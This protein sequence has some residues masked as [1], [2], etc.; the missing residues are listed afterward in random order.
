MKIELLKFM[1]TLDMKDLPE[2]YKSKETFR[3]EHKILCLKRELLKGNMT[4]GEIKDYYDVDDYVIDTIANK[5]Y[6]MSFTAGEY[7]TEKFRMLR[8]I[9]REEDVNAI[10]EKIINC[11]N[12]KNVKLS[13]E[14]RIM[15]AYN[16]YKYNL[17]DT[18][19]ETVINNLYTRLPE[20]SAEFEIVA[21]A[22]KEF[23]VKTKKFNRCGAHDADIDFSWLDL[24]NIDY[25]FGVRNGKQN[26]RY[27]FK[28]NGREKELSIDRAI[29]VMKILSDNNIPLVDCIVKT[30]LRRDLFNELDEFINSL[31]GDKR[32]R[33]RKR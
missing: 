3:L 24:F 16:M 12:S 8:D 15:F 30:A 22:N 31:V 33:V 20:D 5:M 1:N 13:I 25:Y 4:K 23:G 32:V 6:A 29:E 14:Q 10:V 21:F 28:V 18:F 27:K 9:T 11:G 17:V 2:E 19:K 7:V 26:N